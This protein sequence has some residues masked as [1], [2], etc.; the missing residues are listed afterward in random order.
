MIGVGDDAGMS[1][2]VQGASLADLLKGWRRIRRLSQLE[3]SLE[4]GV[5]QRHLSWI[6]TG[7]TR[8][9]RELL[10]V[11]AEALDLQLRECNLLLHAGGFAPMFEQRAL[12]DA[13]MASVREALDLTLEHHEP[14][15]AIVL[16][17]HWNTVLRNG[18]AERFLSL[19]GDPDEVWA[20]V[21]PSGAKNALRMTCSQAG[22]RP[23]IR[24]WDQVAADL[25]VR[26]QREV[27]AAP[28]DAVLAALQAE[29]AELCGIRGSWRTRRA[30]VPS[31][32]PTINLELGVGDVQL[33]L[34]TMLSTFGT[35]VDVTA[36]ELRIET[37][38]PAD[39]ATTAF[40][41]ELA[42]GGGDG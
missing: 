31:L 11:L 41:S 22:L 23:F 33:R 29:L 30:E 15:P 6:E 42:G 13:A 4:A 17:R 8:P 3:L 32:S 10:L 9:S 35:A 28:T 40:F 5:S 14:F 39:R 26:V 16:D 36:D 38:F 19:L 34:F 18:A 12:S 27:V 1:V 37:L 7:R 25:L 21:D 24:N 20:R 2:V